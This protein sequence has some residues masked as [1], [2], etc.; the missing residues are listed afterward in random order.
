MKLPKL[1]PSQHDL[2]PSEFGTTWKLKADVGRGDEPTVVMLTCWELGGA[3][4]DVS[5]LARP[6]EVM[7]AQNP[8]GLVPPVD[9]REPGSA[10]DTILYALAHP[11][12]RHLIVCG[13]SECKTLGLL[14]DD[15]SQNK[16]NPFRD[17]ME[18]VKNR[19]R[20]AY[21]DRP[22]DERLGLLVQES[23]LQQLA[24]LR[25]HEE[26]RSRLEVGN[27]LLHGWVRDDESAAIHVYDA[28]T[29]QFST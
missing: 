8:G 28:K 6:G 19:Y 20:E 10:L 26:I 21:A 9:R 22:A 11:T 25:S 12:V 15:G 29:G 27:L 3:P 7:F 2:P 14:L 1:E 23:V 5:F 24:N 18:S 17:L 16:S 13:H 4:D